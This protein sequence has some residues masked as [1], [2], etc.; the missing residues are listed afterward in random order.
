[1]GESVQIGKA[2]HAVQLQSQLHPLLYS[3]PMV[4]T[5]IISAA[6]LTEAIT[7]LRH[8]WI[9]AFPTDTLYGVAC[10]AQNEEAVRRLFLAKER[11]M[12]VALP[13]MI[14]THEMV[15]YIAEPLPGFVELTQQFW[16]GPLTLVLPKKPVLPDIVTGGLPSLGLRIP[17]HDLTLEVLRQVDVPLAVS[18]ANRS[19]QPPARNAEQAW[20]QLKG[21]VHLIVD[22][23]E[24]P[25]KMPSTVLDLTTEL[26]TILRAG[27]ISADALSAIL[28][29]PIVFEHA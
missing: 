27:A 19:G 1:M 9:V 20:N 26:P 4:S 5:D 23:G 6:Q 18:S 8:G 16:P 13:V 17:D 10:L 15:G 25:G 21:R 28:D 24:T 7:A 29:R 11:A 12:D 22:G 2:V 3:C 14:A